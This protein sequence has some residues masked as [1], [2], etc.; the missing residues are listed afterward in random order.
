MS[1]SKPCP[2]CDCVYC[3]CSDI[4][5]EQRETIT[6]LTAEITT[7]RARLDTASRAASDVPD[8]GA[9]IREVV[10]GQRVAALPGPGGAEFGAFLKRNAE[11]VATWPRAL[12]EAFVLR[13]DRPAT[14]LDPG[15]PRC[16]TVCE[17]GDGAGPHAPANSSPAEAAPPPVATAGVISAGVSL[18]PH[19]PARWL[20]PSDARHPGH[21]AWVRERAG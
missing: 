15:G 2:T 8:E 5:I 14:C 1:T 10:A 3:A 13:P 18:P 9:R 4:V 19:G 20:L 21:V 11:E 6:R 7:L 16:L 12:R 17:C